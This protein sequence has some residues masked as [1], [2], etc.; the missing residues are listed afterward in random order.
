MDSGMIDWGESGN[1]RGFES[2]L[3]MEPSKTRERFRDGKNYGL[4]DQNSSKSLWTG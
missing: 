4:G 3:E 2:L 1:R